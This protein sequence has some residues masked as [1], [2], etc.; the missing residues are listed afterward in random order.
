MISP[1]KVEASRLAREIASQIE[2]RGD[3]HGLWSSPLYDSGVSTLWSIAYVMASPTITRRCQATCCWELRRESPTRR[4]A[5]LWATTTLT[6]GV[7][8]PV[9]TRDHRGTSAS[10]EPMPIMVHHRCSTPE[11]DWTRGTGGKG[12]GGWIVL[13]RNDAFN[14]ADFARLTPGEEDIP[15]E[16]VLA[17]P[18]AL[19]QLALLEDAI[20][21]GTDVAIQRVGSTVEC[22]LSYVWYLASVAEDVGELPAARLQPYLEATLAWQ[23][24]TPAMRTRWASIAEEALVSYQGR[25]AAVR[26]KGGSRAGTTLPTASA[27]ESLTEEVLAEVTAI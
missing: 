24:F 21:L 17:L 15:V 9:R 4:S 6:E 3:R 10:T 18:A 14:R 26:R 5:S 27:I 16:L 11:R 12:V 25:S 19:E 13:A 8:L 7:N 23:E 1:T 20:R 2:S 22:S